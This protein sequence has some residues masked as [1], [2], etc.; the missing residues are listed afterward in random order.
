[1]LIYDPDIDQ[2][3]LS[4]LKDLCENRQT[5]KW[6]CAS[7]DDIVGAEASTVIIYNLEEFHFEA[8][9]RA[10]KNLIIITISSSK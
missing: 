10:I 1:M 8:F 6:K 7:Q 5:P 4:K 2:E 9:T 3:D